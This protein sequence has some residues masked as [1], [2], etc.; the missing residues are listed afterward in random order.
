MLGSADRRVAVWDIS[1]IG[2]EQTP[3]EADDGPPELMFVHGGHTDKVSDISWNPVFPWVIASASDDNIL[4]VIFF[5]TRKF[6]NDVSLPSITVK[7]I[8]QDGLDLGFISTQN[9]AW[10][11]FSFLL[12]SAFF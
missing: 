8:H 9:E 3:E 10:F 6:L 12:P 4:Q 5:S 2:M 11:H 1:N 7:L